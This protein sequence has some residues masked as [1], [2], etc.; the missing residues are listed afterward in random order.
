MGL[1][2]ALQGAGDIARAIGDYQAAGEA[3][4]RARRAREESW[5]AYEEMMAEIRRMEEENLRR[6]ELAQKANIER[7]NA[8]LQL[9]QQAHA[10]EREGYRM[11]RAGARDLIESM[12]QSMRAETDQTAIARGLSGTTVTAG[13]RRAADRER[14]RSLSE[15]GLREGQMDAQHLSEQAG[16]FERHQDII[17][18][19]GAGSIQGRFGLGSAFMQRGFAMED[20]AML[21]AMAR[22]TIPW[23]TLESLFTRGA[24]TA[25]R[26]EAKTDLE[27]Q[28]AD[29]LSPAE[30]DR[31]RETRGGG[32]GSGAEALAAS[33]AFVF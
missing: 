22:R 8:S 9:L 14:V 17:P 11:G 10:A 27:T 12:A 18:Q 3:R 16:L 28:P 19:Y 30:D 15:L 23:H 13:G 2:G 33:Q 6:Q 25:A 31:P 24:E 1:I 21:S 26:Y 32:G 20:L 5:G 29:L 4:R 7:F